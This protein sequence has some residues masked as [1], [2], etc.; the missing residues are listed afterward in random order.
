MHRELRVAESTKM[1]ANCS[2]KNIVFRY[3]TGEWLHGHRG[4][5]LHCR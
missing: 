1:L 2:T 5:G 3:R 4:R